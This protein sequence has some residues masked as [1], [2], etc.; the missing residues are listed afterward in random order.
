MDEDYVEVPHR[1]ICSDG[2]DVGCECS[3][4]QC[5]KALTSVS[6]GGGKVGSYAG[7]SDVVQYVEDSDCEKDAYNFVDGVECIQAANELIMRTL[8]NQKEDE[9][10]A[11]GNKI[12]NLRPFGLRL[13]LTS[14]FREY[15]KKSASEVETGRGL[16]NRVKDDDLGK[17]KASNFTASLLRIGSWER[18]S[19][20]E[21][22][23]VAKCYFAKRKLVWEILEGR[24]KRKIEIQWS[25]IIA[26]QANI[27]DKKPAVLEIELNERPTFYVEVDPQPRKHTIWSS[28][29]DFTGGHANKCRTHYLVF[30]PGSLDTHYEKLLQCDDR[31]LELTKK[32]F[33][34]MPWSPTFPDENGVHYNPRILN[35]LNSY[36][37]MQLPPPS[38]T[39]SMPMGLRPQT[40]SYDGMRH[41]S[42]NELSP[43]SVVD[44]AHSNDQLINDA[45]VWKQGMNSYGDAPA[46]DQAGRLVAHVSSTQL[47][48]TLPRQSFVQA[49][50]D[51]SWHKCS[52]ID[53]FFYQGQG[54]ARDEA[55]YNLTNQFLIGAQLGSCNGSNHL[56][57][58]D[59][60]TLVLNPPDENTK[61][62]MNPAQCQVIDDYVHISGVGGQFHQKQEVVALPAEASLENPVAHIPADIPFASCDQSYQHQASPAYSRV[63]QNCNNSN[64]SMSMTTGALY[65]PEM[66]AAN[67]TI[68]KITGRGYATEMSVD[69]LYDHQNKSL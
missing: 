2:G 63:Y 42:C 5:N 45:R 33:P 39:A 23:L 9:Q 67:P 3:G 29:S 16:L 38:L 14:S 37:G 58:A 24:L 10:T 13:N 60:L 50:S 59:S 1:F 8:E 65:A 26:I 17:M 28:T 61:V 21:G 53:P 54:I 48:S 49:N 34:S 51:F 55:S 57:G 52:Q 11:L 66:I 41:L 69:N 19:R 68:G 20:N 12:L 27:Q 46:K 40:R 15:K 6:G 22:D 56:P 64:D 32:A 44:F 7:L 4:S 62:S 31:L 47:N 43:I 35:M 25:N 18:V 30:P 36:Q